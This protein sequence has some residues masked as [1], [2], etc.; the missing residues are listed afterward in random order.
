MLKLSLRLPP[1]LRS[2]QSLLYTQYIHSIAT[3]RIMETLQPRSRSVSPAGQ[4]HKKPRLDLD[5][6]TGVVAA[7]MMVL[8]VPAD[9]MTVQSGP[10]SQSKQLQGKKRGGKRDKRKIK[11]KLP[12]PYSPEDVVHRDVISLLGQD[13]VDRLIEEGKDWT[14]PFQMREEVELTVSSISS[15]GEYYNCH[16]YSSSLDSST[17]LASCANELVTFALVLY[18]SPMWQLIRG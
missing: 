13:V 1:T 9:I 2:L 6:K 7:E 5:Q 10:T 15:H 12:E 16:E 14:S 8:D 17:R 11:H 3:Q 4:P 18:V